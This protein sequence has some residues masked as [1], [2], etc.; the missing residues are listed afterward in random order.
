MRILIL[1]TA[2]LLSP[3]LLAQLSVKIK[4]TRS[5]Y[6]SYES[7]KLEVSIRNQSGRQ[8]NLHNSATNGGWIEFV[9]RNQSGRL[10]HTVK[11]QSYA[12]TSIATAENVKSTFT[13]S[14]SFNLDQ[15]GNYSVSAIVR[16]PNQSGDQG[17]RSASCYFTVNRG[18]ITWRSKV[19]VPGL[20]GDEREYRII[21]SGSSRST[22]PQLYIQVEDVK[23]GQ[24]L[25]TYPMGK[26]LSF[27]RPQKA[28][29]R[30]NNL[31]VLFLTTPKLYCH[32]VVNPSGNTIKR[33]YLKAFNSTHPTLI[34]EANGTVFVNNATV[35]DPQ[36]EREENSKFH[37][38]SEVPGG[39]EQ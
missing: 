32:T 3:S 33:N 10:V 39:F 29:D 26:Y 11:K 20:S 21:E 28:I 12:P 23:K 25:A 24:M 36:K 5:E 8:L 18:A 1:L 37:N 34:T 9:V 7:V 27:R 4:P 30:K 19:G 38:L 2:L 35:Y 15:P 14:N 17:T 22:A 13:L 16:T 31:H 6:I